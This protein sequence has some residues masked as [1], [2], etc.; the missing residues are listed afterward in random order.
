MSW[1]KGK[2][3]KN[4]NAKKKAL[5][6]LFGPT[7]KSVFSFKDFFSLFKE[8]LPNFIAGL[9]HL[10]QHFEMKCFSLDGTVQGM[11]SNSAR[12]VAF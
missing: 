4:V 9:S 2:S 11:R 12:V 8:L 7:P 10:S 1:T 3:D 6:V 5:P